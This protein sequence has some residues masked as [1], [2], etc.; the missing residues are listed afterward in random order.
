M[1]KPI[2]GGKSNFKPSK[3]KDVPDGESFVQHSKK[4]LES[5]AMRSLSRYGFLM[6]MRLEVEHL[7]HAGKENGNLI[8]TYDQFVEWGIPRRQIRPTID[9]LLAAGLLHI[10]RAGLARGINGLPTLYLLTYLKSKFASGNGAPRY[11]EPSNEWQKLRTK[12]P[13]RPKPKRGTARSK[14]TGASGHGGN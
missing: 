6:L 7:N 4:L 1:S 3:I 9:E 11:I 5:L 12:P 8:V 14:F 10:T 2:I 13:P